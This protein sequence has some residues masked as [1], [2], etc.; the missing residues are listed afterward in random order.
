MILE[1]CNNQEKLNRENTEIYFLH[2]LYDHQV[3]N[4]E[5][6]VYIL[7]KKC[8]GLEITN[9]NRQHCIFYVHNWLTLQKQKRIIE[10]RQSQL[11]KKLFLQ[12]SCQRIKENC[13]CSKYQIYIC[14]SLKINIVICFRPHQIF[15][16]KDLIGLSQVENISYSKQFICKIQ[17]EYT[18]RKILIFYAVYLRGKS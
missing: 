17:Q 12:L 13:L 1:L 8:N 2:Q 6:V 3:Q 15:E 7:Y 16:Q 18:Y 14:L 10:I 11:L 4:I 5:N 9:R